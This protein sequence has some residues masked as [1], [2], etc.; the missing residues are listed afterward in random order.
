MQSLDIT[1]F[2]NER[3]PV[4]TLVNPTQE[5]FLE[6]LCKPVIR[7]TKE[8][9]TLLGP[10]KTDRTFRRKNEHIKSISM[11][12]FDIDKAKG[13]TFD[14]IYK[15]VAQYTGLIHTSWSHSAENTK[16]RILLFLTSPI[17]SEK[18]ECVR[19]NFLSTHSNLAEIIDQ[20]CKEISRGYFAFACPN[21]R[22]ELARSKVLKGRPVQWE[23]YEQ[24]QSPLN[25]DF[26]TPFNESEIVPEGYRYTERCKLIGRL[27]HQGLPLEKVLRKVLEWNRIN[28]K[29]PDDENTVTRNVNGIWEKDKKAKLIF[30]NENETSTCEEITPKRYKLLSWDDLKQKKEL[31]WVVKKIFPTKGLASIYGPSQSGKSFLA[32]D[33]ALHI[34]LGIEW[35]GNRV[36]SNDVIYCMLEGEYGLKNRVKAWEKGN[37]KSCPNTF[38]AFLDPFRINNSQDVAD[39]ARIL[40][41]ECVVIIDTLNRS[42]PDA[43][44]NSSKDMGLII[45]GMKKIQS[46]CEGLVICVHHTGKD[47]S[48]GLRGHSS[49]LASLD[50]AIQVERTLTSRNWALAKSKEGEDDKTEHFELKAQELGKDSDGDLVTSCSV[51]WDKHPLTVRKEPSGKQQ[52]AALSVVTKLLSTS[53]T[54][55]K[56]TAGSDTRCIKVEI[57]IDR[58]AET[59]TTH[60]KN[61]RRSTARRV[62]QS[63]IDNEFL[64]T[65]TSNSEDWL[66][67]K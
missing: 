56:A 31:E 19:T 44:E 23:K 28:C 12:V 66:W 62:I 46:Y 57:A 21:E 50:S 34:A 45:D 67:E 24:Y 20:G 6:V 14:D 51:S 49:L 39:F 37:S 52:R 22:K 1:I 13:K 58:F 9:N 36:T 61:K 7:E 40:P 25:G 55:N 16:C 11:L 29:P 18:F 63:L 10:Y 33:I 27:I 15:L 38:K 54:K 3:S 64:E 41:K 42:A 17:P 47:V 32:I 65:G 4:G 48:K 60:Q 53:N 5:S 35:F 30:H 26:N 43:D 8:G 59:L 2:N